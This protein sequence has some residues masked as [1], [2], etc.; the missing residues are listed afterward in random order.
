MTLQKP[1]P[2]LFFR[3]QKEKKSNDPFDHF[4]AAFKSA[5]AHVPAEFFE[6]SFFYAFKNR[7]EQF[8]FIFEMVIQITRADTHFLGDLRDDRRC[9]CAG[10]A[11]S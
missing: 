2:L 5:L 7:H 9:T 8:V 10:S 11:G 3:G 6:D 4:D 1:E